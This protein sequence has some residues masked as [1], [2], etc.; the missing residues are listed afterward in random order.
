MFLE[1][2]AFLLGCS[3]CC[4]IT[5]HNILLGFFFISLWYQLLF[6]LLSFHIYVFEFLIYSFW[7]DWLM[8][9]HLCLYFQKTAVFSPLIFSIIFSISILF[10]FSL[11]LI[12]FLMPTLDS[13]FSPFLSL[14]GGRLSCLF[15]IFF[16]ISWGRLTSL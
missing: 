9:Y 5:V 6:L 13:F 1:I 14:L 8:V 12:S 16:L 7:W 10:T 3:V 11:N 2:S 4:H 15:E